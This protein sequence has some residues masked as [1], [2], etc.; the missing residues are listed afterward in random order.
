MRRP[1]LVLTLFVVAMWVLLFF[2]FGRL[3]TRKGGPQWIPRGSEW[4]V[5]ICAARSSSPRPGYS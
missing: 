3:D 4:S 5:T 1:A 2:L